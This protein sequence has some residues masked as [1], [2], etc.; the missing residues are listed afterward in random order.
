MYSYYDAMNRKAH[1]KHLTFNKECY[2]SMQSDWNTYTISLSTTTYL[3]TTT[4]KFKQKAEQMKTEQR[5]QMKDSDPS[6]E[7]CSKKERA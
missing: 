7:S 3:F 2:K 5:Y 4:E 6:N 1:A